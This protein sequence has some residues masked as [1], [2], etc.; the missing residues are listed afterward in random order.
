MQ[1]QLT[2]EFKQEFARY[3]SQPEWQW[4]WV[5]TQTFDNR[6]QSQYSTL[7]LHSWRYFMFELARTACMNYGF[8][9]TEGVK[10]GRMHWHAIVHVKSNLLGQPEMDEMWLYMF[11][12][13]GRNL[14]E[15]F[16]D[17]QGSLSA[18][19]RDPEASPIAS[20]LTKYVAK[21]SFSDDTSWDFEGFLGGR[22]A[23]TGQIA[24][25]IG[26]PTSRDL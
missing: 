11:K 15:G 17:T 2:N 8:V 19:D 5:I 21:E 6:K 13:Y 23:D 10:S 24:R 16:R 4:N 7:S 9:F 3:L 26:L 18:V 14:I 12:R 25:A 1:T 22:R 20:Y